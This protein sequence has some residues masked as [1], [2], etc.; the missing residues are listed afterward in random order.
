MPAQRVGLAL[1]LGVEEPYPLGGNA[2]T[3]IARHQQRVRQGPAGAVR[4][5]AHLRC[6]HASARGRIAAYRPLAG[7]QAQLLPLVSRDGV[8]NLWVCDLR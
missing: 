1:A 5:L 7:V 6:G 4:A 2:G 8:G 3:V